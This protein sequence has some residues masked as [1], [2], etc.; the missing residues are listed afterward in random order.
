MSK[1]K[2]YGVL[3][4]VYNATISAGGFEKRIFWLAEASTARNASTWKI[5][6]HQGMCNTLDEFAPGEKVQVDITLTGR[7]WQGSGKEDVFHTLKCTK[8]E[9]WNPEL[10]AQVAKAEKS[11]EKITR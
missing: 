9:K 8:I 5:E 4:R 6:A 1:L 3:H 11:I 2:L 7:V 10:E